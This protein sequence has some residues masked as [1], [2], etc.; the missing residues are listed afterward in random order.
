LLRILE[1]LKL[2][3]GKKSLG[4]VGGLKLKQKLINLFNS[5]TPI[6][7]YKNTDLGQSK[8]F[9]NFEDS[10]SI[11]QVK[12]KRVPALKTL[13]QNRLSTNDIDYLKY[14]SIFFNIFEKYRS[15]VGLAGIKFQIA[16]R[17]SK[18]RSAARASV[19][20]RSKGFFKFNSKNALIDH[21]RF[22]YK[23]KNGSF[24]VKIWLS[25]NN[26]L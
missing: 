2:I 1:N 11:M 6:D 13:S 9:K 22:I 14:N 18:K 25:G 3:K 19:N 20:T 16:G 24:S 5:S 15:R 23:N 12:D 21:S 7:I 8:L 4:S 17:L 26:S 10:Y